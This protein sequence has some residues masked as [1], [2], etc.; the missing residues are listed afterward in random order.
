MQN[1][2]GGMTILQF[3]RER[4][5]IFLRRANGEPKPWTTDEV[6]QK[7]FFTNI[8]RELDRTSVVM[9]DVLS[10]KMDRPNFLALVVI[11]RMVSNA[12]FNKEIGFAGSYEVVVATYNNR[13]GRGDSVRTGA[14][15]SCQSDAALFAS[16]K[17]F[18][19]NGDAI[20]SKIISGD[21]TVQGAFKALNGAKGLGKFLAWQVALDLQMYG[22]VRPSPDFVV[23][24]PGAELGLKLA[25]HTDFWALL[26]EINYSL[27]SEVPSLEAKDLEHALCEY[28]KY[29]KLCSGGG[30]KRLYKS[31]EVL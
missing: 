11:H 21:Q 15:T 22:A 26:K 6:L 28:G 24:G 20:L 25:G 16:W 18:F 12:D 17:Y 8:F 2:V 7:Y 13:R 3:I 23:L 29:V 4:H 19:E 5:M 30:K 27:P 1:T 9:R 10:G 14:F 31:K